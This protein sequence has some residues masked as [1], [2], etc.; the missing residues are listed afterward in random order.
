MRMGWNAAG[1]V[2][3]SMRIDRDRRSRPSGASDPFCMRV[4]NSVFA[5]S[6]VP[7]ERIE[8][9]L[10]WRIATFMGVV[11]AVY[12]AISMFMDVCV[13]VLLIHTYLRYPR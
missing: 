5:V 6:L 4:M 11:V 9:V 12:R 13:R 2:V 1:S 10:V 3:F 8:S 7:N